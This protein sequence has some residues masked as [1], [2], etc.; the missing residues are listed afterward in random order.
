MASKNKK[1]IRYTDRDFSSVKESLVEYTKRYYPD[2]FKDF[3]EA[4]FGSL[5]LDTVSYVGDVLSFYL[6]YQV[7]ESFLDTSIEYD[8]ILRLGEQVGYKQHLKSN[9]FGFV[10]LY[11]LCPVTTDGSGPDTSYLPVLAKGSKFVSD[12]GQ[13]F[14]LIEDI[15]FKNENNQIVVA[16]ALPNDGNPTAYAVK[17]HGR[18]ISGELKEASV[19]VGEFKRFLSIPLQ[20]PNISEI[21]SVTDTEGH[22]YFEV[23]YLSQNVVFRSV[24]N[25]DPSTRDYTPNIIIPSTVPRRFVVST[26]TSGVSLK[27][28]YGSDSSLKMDN[29][30][31]PSNVIL[32]MHGRD[33]EN[34][35]T[36]DPS[37]LLET[38]KFG[39]APTN[40]TLRIVYRSNNNE[41]VN[42]AS[43]ALSTVVDPVFV[44][45]SAAVNSSKIA[46]VKDSVEIINEA[47]I[48][49]DVRSP[50]INELKQRVN[51]TFVSQNRAVT[52]EDYEAVVYRMPAK[53]GRIKRT[54]IVRD[55]DSFK[56]NLNL[57]V[58]S[59]DGNGNLI[60]SNQA[61]KNNLKIWL[62][63]YR[64]I[65]DTIDILDTKVV[66]VAIK[67]IAVVNYDQDKFQAL[68]VAIETIKEMFLEKMDIGQ[69]IYLSSI[70]NELN[71][72]DE[73][74]DVVDA[75]IVN[76]TTVGGLYSDISLN[77]KEFL[78]ADG[79]ILY[80]PED[81][82]YELKY[83]SLDIKGTIR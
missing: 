16:T 23:G 35:A 69:P 71:N 14:T 1:L 24:I 58:A 82:I 4:S 38:D 13:M 42:V 30:T 74:V 67:F 59:E 7:N 65:N 18:V 9:S 70:Y 36:F 22:E 17:A 68:N 20:D 31:H 72:L 46:F 57:Y 60:V 61:L 19:I 55:R 26:S 50:T 80:A 77:L 43:R 27:F 53:F 66:N 6:D 45:G 49:G 54:K 41:T 39:I 3:S 51:D 34:D 47:P 52:A 79:R 40:T 56:R 2:T 44:F 81:V 76:D 12:G 64:M 29:V 83:P 15:D 37:K 33:Y 10:T 62:N 11:I 5:M 63:K 32:K 78:S 8:N 28:G 25:K 21:V 48:I 73:I 75:R